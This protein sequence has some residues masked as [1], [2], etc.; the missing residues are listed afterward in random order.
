MFMF[1]IWLQG[2]WLPLHG[3]AYADTPLHAGIDT[4]PL[5]LGFVVCGP[6]GG[7]LSDRYGARVLA[8]GGVLVVG[9]AAALMMT[10]PA[11]FNIFEFAALLTLMGGGMGFF[12]APNTSQIMS[13]VPA[14]YR[15]LAAGM[16]STVLNAGLTISQA[17]FFTVVIG[18]LA[19]TLRPAL[20][21]GVTQAGL[22]P[23]LAGAVSTL[24]RKRDLRGHAGI[25]PDLPPH[26]GVRA[27]GTRPRR[28]G[29]GCRP[30]FF[31]AL[32]AQPFV[33]GIPGCP[34]GLRR[35]VACSLGAASA[36]FGSGSPRSSEAP[37]GVRPPVGSAEPIPDQVIGQVD[38]VPTR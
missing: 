2:I 11:N 21:V 37:R 16:R 15:G 36:L 9:L 33:A 26:P 14:R 4:M 3:V 38:T 25:R 7:W 28:R 27:F 1:I 18:S 8:T 13:S 12:S 32:L 31:A 34:A 35:H 22:P 10:L 17:V 5:M 20:L 19:G 30:C 6:L 29:P 24:A 23:T